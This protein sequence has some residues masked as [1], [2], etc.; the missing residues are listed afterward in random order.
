MLVVG[1]LLLNAVLTVRAHQANSH[2]D[3]GWEKF[4]D[5]VVAWLNKHTAGTVFMLWGSYAQ[6]KGARIDKASISC[7]S[8]HSLWLIM[9]MIFFFNCE[10]CFVWK[11]AVKRAYFRKY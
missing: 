3:H 1:V 8:K 9:Y 7:S 6:K 10:H 11:I 2:K 5:A 4:T